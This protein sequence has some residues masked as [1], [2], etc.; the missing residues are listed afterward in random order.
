LALKPGYERRDRLRRRLRRRGG[1]LYCGVQQQH[2]QVP[3]DR[4]RIMCVTLD[5]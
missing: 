5:R 1:L 4:V 3:E 2:A